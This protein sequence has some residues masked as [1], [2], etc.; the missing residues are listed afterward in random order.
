M[1]GRQGNDQLFGGE[2]S[3]VIFGDGLH[4]LYGFGNDTIHGDDGDDILVGESTDRVSSGALDIIYGDAGNDLIFGGGGNDWLFGGDGGDIVDGGEGSD[5]IVGGVGADILVGSADSTAAGGPAATTGGDLFSYSLLADGGDAIYG[6][7]LNTGT[8]SDG[9]DLRP[10][11]AGLGYAGNTPRADGYLFVL[12]NGSDTDVFVD[13][14]GAAGGVQLTLMAH[15][16]SVTAS[17]LT[18]SYFLFQ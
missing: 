6:F 5:F 13:A 3:D 7:D 4:E 17:S 2:G 8:A 16:V 15:F 1:D 11:F 12:Q 10:L 14:N 9:I 18:D